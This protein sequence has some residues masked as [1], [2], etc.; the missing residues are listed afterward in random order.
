MVGFNVSFYQE[1]SLHGVQQPTVPIELLNPV[2][3]LRPFIHP[4]THF[5]LGN[6]FISGG[7]LPKTQQSVKYSTI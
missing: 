1:D 6:D 7:W 3:F 5:P 4:F 2:V